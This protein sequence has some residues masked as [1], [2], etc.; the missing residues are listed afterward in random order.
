MALLPA[1]IGIVFYW[2]SPSKTSQ[3]G[4][5]QPPLSQT[6]RKGNKAESERLTTAAEVADFKVVVSLLRKH[7]GKT[8]EELKAEGK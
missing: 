7:G 6:I 5:D 3:A 8:G 1:I 2:D 4:E